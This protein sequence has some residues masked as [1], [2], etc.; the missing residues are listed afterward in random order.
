MRR[1]GFGVWLAY[2]LEGSYEELPPTLFEELER[3]RRWCQGNIQHLRLMLMKG[4]SFG[5][6]ILF[7][8][9]NLFY[10]SSFLWLFLLCLM[11]VHAVADFFHTVVYFSA[12]RTLFP[13]W[14]ARFPE[15]S[16]RLLMVTAAFLLLPKIM[17]VFLIVLSPDRAAR[18]GGVTRLSISVVLETI[19]STLLAPLRMI[20]HAWYVVLNLFGQKLVWKTQLRR[21]RKTSFAEAFGAYWPG[22]LGALVWAVIS[23]AVNMTL[24]WWVSAI[25]LPLLFAVPI[26]V[27]C[28]YP[29]LGLFFRRY[30]L[31][32]TPV[33]TAPS[34]IL[35]NYQ[36]FFMNIE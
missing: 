18:F 23:Y 20:F 32:L 7:L 29:S 5:H 30:G 35:R 24:F 17:S 33:E 4:V 10:F 16:F 34:G 19:F 11:T 15:L 21:S 3:D 13:H 27:F 31:F 36:K 2:E 8:N 1:A 14:P 9:G 26:S 12:E 22:M 25:V 6:R 28:S